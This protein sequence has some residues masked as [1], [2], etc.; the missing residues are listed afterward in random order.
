MKNDLLTEDVINCLDDDVLLRSKDDVISL[1]SL[2]K[3]TNIGLGLLPEVVSKNFKGYVDL[4]WVCQLY[5]NKITLH[6]AT[7]YPKVTK[8][9]QDLLKCID[10]K[11]VNNVLSS[12][13]YEE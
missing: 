3:K 2:L 9:M 1:H 5:G 8:T 12:N 11:T 7:S 4:P 10:S 13:H 6:L